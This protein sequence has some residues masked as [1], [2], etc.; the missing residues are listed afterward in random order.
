M[1]AHFEDNDNDEDVDD[2]DYKGTSISEMLAFLRNEVSINE[3]EIINQDNSPNLLL[4]S[5]GYTTASITW[6]Q[7]K[8]FTRD[9]ETSMT[10]ASWIATG[11]L[12]PQTSLPQDLRT[13]WRVRGHLQVKEG[14]PMMSERVIIPKELRP[15]VLKTLHSAHQGVYTMTLRAQDTTY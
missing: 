12:G 14:V 5:F 2:D 6:D 11:C 4:A 10:L 7:I 8:R 15:R 13:Y 1:N 3:G 9:N